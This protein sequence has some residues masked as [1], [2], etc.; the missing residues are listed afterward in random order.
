VGAD[1]DPRQADLME[2]AY[3]DALGQDCDLCMRVHKQKDQPPTRKSSSCPSP[4]LE[5]ASSTHFV[6]NGVPAVNFHFKRDQITDPNN[7]T[8]PPSGK[9][10]GGEAAGSEAVA[11]ATWVQP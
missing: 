6:I 3:A 10:S 5:R 4:A 11:V 8:P 1:K 9:P 2:L 7:P